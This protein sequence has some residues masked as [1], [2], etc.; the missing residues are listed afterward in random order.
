MLLNLVLFLSLANAHERGYL[1]GPGSNVTAVEAVEAVAAVKPSTELIVY[2]NIDSMFTKK[3]TKC[4]NKEMYL[5]G[6]NVPVYN[7]KTESEL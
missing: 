2:K 7:N 6:N 1:R 3:N 5:W 4:P